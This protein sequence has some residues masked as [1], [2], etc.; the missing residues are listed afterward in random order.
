MFWFALVLCYRC[1]LRISHVS[2]SP[3][4]L[5]VKD[6][7]FWPGGMDVT[8]FSSKTIQF[9]E[10]VQRIPV[11]EAKGS[12]LCRVT[13]LN[14]YVDRCGAK[15]SE[16]LFRFKYRE[17][18]DRLKCLCAKARLEGDFVTHKGSSLLPALLSAST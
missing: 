4:T 5:R 10:R 18:C 15:G 12:P 7:C 1:L 11:L 8:V 9:K 13:A 17:F 2:I 6:F 3:H 16:W 14:V